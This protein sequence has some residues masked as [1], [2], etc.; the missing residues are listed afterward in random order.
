V[1]ENARVLVLNGSSVSGLA[2][3]TGDFLSGLGLNIVDIGDA[4][5]QYENTLIIDYAGKPYTSKQ[6][7]TVLRLPLSRVLPGG[8]P[9]GEYDVTLILGNDFELPES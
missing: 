1:E 6:L 3:S 4:G 2:R 8:S 7:A 5:D 9:D